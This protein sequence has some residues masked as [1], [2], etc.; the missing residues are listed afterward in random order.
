M[1]DLSGFNPTQKIARGELNEQAREDWVNNPS[2]T[3]TTPAGTILK[4]LGQVVSDAEDAVADVLSSA[5]VIRIGTYAEMKALSS[6]EAAALGAFG[7]TNRG[8]SDFVWDASDL[9]TEVANDP[10]GGMVVPL[11]GEDGSNGAFRRVTGGSTIFNAVWFNAVGDDSTDNSSVYNDMKTYIAS[12]AGGGDMYWP[13]GTYQFSDELV[14]DV[15][16]M[17]IRGDG[18]ISD[19]NIITSGKTIF[20]PMKTTGAGIRVKVDRWGLQGVFMGAGAARQAALRISK[21]NYASEGLTRDDQNYGIWIEPDD[22]ASSDEVGNFYCDRV[23]VSDQPNAG[24]AIA[25]KTYVSYMNMC[26]G[27]NNGD[28]GFACGNGTYTGRTNLESTGII[29]ATN[30]EGYQ[31]D[32]HGI[33]Q[34]HPEDVSGPSGLRMILNNCDFYTNGQNGARLYEPYDSYYVADNSKIEY[35]AFNGNNLRGGVYVAGQNIEITN[36]RYLDISP[37]Y[38]PVQ[39]DG[40]HGT[41]TPRT[42]YGVKVWGGYVTSSGLCD[43]FVG[44]VNSP[45]NV[46]VEIDVLV[47][48][49]AEAAPPDVM[50]RRKRNALLWNLDLT[51]TGDVTRTGNT[52]QTGGFTIA[53]GVMTLNRTN[54]VPLIVNR[55]GTSGDM[56]LWRKDGATVGSVS[57]SGGNV[58]YGT[59]TGIHWTQLLG[60]VAIPDI[61]P[62]TIISTI[63]A[64]CSWKWDITR[65]CVK[66]ARVLAVPADQE[67][68]GASAEHDID[69]LTEAQI[70]DEF[71]DAEG[72]FWRVIHVSEPART[73]DHMAWYSGELGDGDIWIDDDGR[74]H[75]IMEEEN[76]TLAMS[77]ISS[78]P[79]DKAVYGVFFSHSNDNGEPDFN[80]ASVGEYFIRIAAGETVEPGDL[81]DSNGDGCGRVQADDIMRSSTVAKVTA[82]IPVETYEDGSY[83]V[84]CTLHCG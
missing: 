60:Q 17:V 15:I 21:D 49:F 16:G 33:A 2:G 80:V 69:V 83:L 38:R 72:F 7:T 39:V 47:G 30:C 36:N 41:G 35:S 67:D 19:G 61:K 4:T 79:G 62:G 31:N 28:H 82:A 12:L 54:N 81:I 76:K 32:G 13:A 3:V 71:V 59:F 27:R 73:E 1:A 26:G 52:T 34:G 65:V 43:Y 51:Q 18:L 63:N 29:L 53:E 5:G 55:N 56:L 8:G 57:E 24:W 44:T 84:P 64:M 45:K 25:G 78:T 58:A 20:K 74:E 66:P 75:L 10:A 6:V 48:S 50:I 40:T 11:T 14:H 70:G 77:E 23:W 42:T 9:S 46:Q 68:N 22:V 37:S